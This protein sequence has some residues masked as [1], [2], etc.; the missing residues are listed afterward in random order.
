[1]EATYPTMK[2]PR[3][4]GILG[5][6]DKLNNLNI[7]MNRAENYNTISDETVKS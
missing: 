7:A 4:D 3:S 1:M 6:Y 5:A 2:E